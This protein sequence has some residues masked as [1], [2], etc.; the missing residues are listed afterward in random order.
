MRWTLHR[1]ESSIRRMRFELSSHFSPCGDQPQAIAE[2][3]QGVREG[4]RYQTLLG[5][6][7]SGKTYT[8]ASLI[9]EVQKPTLIMAHNKTLA[10]QLFSEFRQFFPN[11]AVEYFVSYYDYYQPEAY[12]PASDTYIEK[13][14][15]INEHIDRMR[16]AATRAL[17]EREDVVIVASVSCI[18]GLGS[19]EAYAGMLLYMELGRSMDPRKAIAKLVELQY[20]RN[21]TGFQRGCFRVR[22]DVL[23]IFPAHAEDFAVRVEFFGDEIDAIS[24]ID[25]LTGKRLESLHKYT[26]FPCSHFVTPKAQL[27]RAMQAIREELDLRLSELRAAGRLLEAQRLEQ[28]TLFDLEMMRETGFCTGVENYSRHLTGR[29]PGEPPPTL[30]DYLPSNA[31]VILDESHVTVPQIGAMFRGDRARKQTL[32]D[33][34]FRLPSALDNRPL[35]FHEFEAIVPQTIY[36]SATPG[37]YELRQSG[38]VFVEQVIRPTGLLDPEVEVRPAQSQVDDFVDQARAVIERG[39]RVL[40]TCLTKR[41]AEDLSAYLGELNLRVRYLHSDIDTIERVE[42]LRDLRLGSFDILI[43]INLLREGLDLPEVALVCIFDADQEGFLRSQRSLIQTIGRAARNAE[44]RVILYAER[45]TPSMQA[46]IDETARRRRKQ[47]AWN[48]A[49]GITPRTI[50]KQI[51][52]TLQAIYELDYARIPE[53]AEP[54]PKDEAARQARRQELERLMHEAAADL[55]FE[56]AARYRDAWQ[57]LA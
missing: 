6:T 3:A 51:P 55:R 44:G 5:V 12:V 14:S 36:V 16:H 47:M 27:E 34:G 1:S 57:A 35:Q 49:Q 38:G 25:P 40:A 13:D 17:L 37:D 4:K 18:Y 48:E 54:E 10:A 45:I 52:E 29:A 43:G 15:S 31:L 19:P 42:I 7:G 23:E 26:V 20:Q 2:L 22:G 24:R 28:R 33:Y 50:C 11:N 39:H 9:A 30:L 53:V 56:D 32:V 8:M 46:A 41:M 21:Q